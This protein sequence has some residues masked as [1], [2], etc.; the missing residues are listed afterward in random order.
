MCWH[1]SFWRGT[2]GQIISKWFFV[3]F[4]FLQKRNENRSTW[5]TIV[6]K[7]NSFVRFLEEIEGIKNHFEVIWPL[8]PT[9][10][11]IPRLN[12]YY[13]HVSMFRFSEKAIESRPNLSICLSLQLKFKELGNL[14]TSLWDFLINSYKIGVATS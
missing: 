10:F 8:R 6:V 14:F 5:G 3:V 2:K 4:D 12:W 9:S 13:W 11:E 7:L 1:K